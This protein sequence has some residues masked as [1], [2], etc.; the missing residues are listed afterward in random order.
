MPEIAFNWIDGRPDN[1]L[2]VLRDTFESAGV[3]ASIPTDIEAELWS[4]LALIASMSGVGAVTRAPVGIQRS[5]PEARR[6]LERTIG[7][8]AAVA[9]A[10]GIP[11]S[12]SLE[13]KTI[14]YIDTLPAV[15]VASMHRDI[16]EGRPSEL[17]SQNG[18]IVRLGRAAGVKVPVNEFIYSVLLPLDQRARGQLQF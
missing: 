8:T 18:T 9:R 3:T 13:K 5:V 4:K 16:V 11:I 12:P 10:Y 14:S 17:D 1:R 6:L 2:R 15:M 7:E